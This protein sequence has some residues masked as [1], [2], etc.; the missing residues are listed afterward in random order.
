MQLLSE[1]EARNWCSQAA[2]SFWRGSDRLRSSRLRITVPEDA[3]AVVALAYVLT[4]TGVDEYAEANYTESLLWLRR[5]EI[6]SESIDR[7]GYVFLKALRSESGDVRSL[8]DAPA[9]LFGPGE[10]ELAHACVALPMLFQWD[11]H[12][13]SKD[14]ALSAFI[15]HEGYIDL[16]VE[17]GSALEMLLE[18]FADWRPVM[19]SEEGV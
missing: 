8:D 2:P 5:W 9:H 12:F 7:A 15:S 17:D 4:I 10:F 19:L 18:R 13:I 14:G 11:A 6:W 1:T 3:I 16:N